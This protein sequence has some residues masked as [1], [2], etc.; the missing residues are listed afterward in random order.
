MLIDTTLREGEQKFGVY[1]DLETKKQIINGL[2][3]FGIEEIEL[4]VIGPDENKEISELIHW[5]ETLTQKTNRSIWS[6]CKTEYVKLVAK[7]GVERINIGVPV[8]DNHISKRLKLSRAGLLERLHQVVKAAQD[9]GLSYISVGLEDLCRA[10][11]SFALEVARTAVTSGAKRIRLS[12]TVGLLSPIEIADLVRKFK[13]A[14]SCHLAVH[15]HNDFAQGTANAITAILGGAEFVDVSILGLGERAG[16]AALEEV[17][18]YLYFRKKAAHYNMPI[19]RDLCT[20]VSKAAKIP[21]SESKP[22]VGKSI[23]ACESGLHIHGINIDPMLFEP[24]APETVGA[25]R[26]IGLGKKSGRAAVMSA[27]KRFYPSCSSHCLE[28][29]SSSLVST[30][31]SLAR[32]QG[33]PLTE[34]EIR[35]LL[36][37]E[38]KNPAQICHR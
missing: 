11:L 14:L 38:F 37:A 6:P 18:A 24:F 5:T 19:V 16:I 35:G 29:L 12:D 9:A 20:L 31:R 26:K 21:I 34:A 36:Q 27:L 15:C 3:E 8:S 17:A 10:D 33:R 23:F 28:Q 25:K 13:N 2:I 1:F 30:V 22:I 32:K 7:L 4:G